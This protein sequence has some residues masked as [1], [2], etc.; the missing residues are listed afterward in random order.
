MKKPF[1]YE[2]MLINIQNLNKTEI[3]K[4]K[5]SHNYAK[6]HKRGLRPLVSPECAT[7]VQ[8]MNKL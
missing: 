2:I 5:S 3:L 6:L 4:K 8:K 7:I 1:F